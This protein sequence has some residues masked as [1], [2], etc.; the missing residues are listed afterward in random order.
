M[1]SGEQAEQRRCPQARPQASSAAGLS[2]GACAQRSIH[3]RLRLGHFKGTRVPERH[4]RAGVLVLARAS[5]GAA[6]AAPLPDAESLK[7]TLAAVMRDP[8]DT[9]PRPWRT[10][11]ATRLAATVV[12]ADDAA[13]QVNVTPVEMSGLKPPADADDALHRLKTNAVLYRQNY[14]LVF[15]GALCFGALRY[16]SGPFHLA[17]I[18]SLVA[19]ALSSS[20]R[21]LGEV[22]LASDGRFVWNAKRVAGVDRALLLRFAPVVGFLAVAACPLVRERPAV[23]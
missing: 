11:W 20:D 19:F 12:S 10:F 5:G 7:A 2:V 17:A 8:W 6:G 14:A 18:V 21:L 23:L 15:L 22:Q 9:P 13:G 16:R 3:A 4:S 1:S